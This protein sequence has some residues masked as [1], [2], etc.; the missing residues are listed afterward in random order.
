MVNWF[1]IMGQTSN[2][3]GIIQVESERIARL[4]AEMDGIKEDVGDI[5]DD[6]AE[7]RKDG[8]TTSIALAE[9]SMTLKK[10]GEVSE[11]IKSLDTRVSKLEVWFYRIAGFGSAVGVAWVILGDKIKS[12]IS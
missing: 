12:L 1:S 7:I 2:N 6:I 10:F 5:K 4:E 11:D 8:N 9:I 3:E